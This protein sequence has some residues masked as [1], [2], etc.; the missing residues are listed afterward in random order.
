[1][2]IHTRRQSTDANNEMTQMLKL[3]NKY[4]KAAIIKENA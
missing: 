3:S 2:P 4:V 1:M